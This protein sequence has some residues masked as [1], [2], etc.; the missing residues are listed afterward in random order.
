MML[1]QPLA[2]AAVREKPGTGATGSCQAA[3]G[4]HDRQSRDDEID[5]S[6]IQSRGRVS[7]LGKQG[8]EIMNLR[9]KFVN[10]GFRP[11]HEVSLSAPCVVVLVCPCHLP[12]NVSD[13]LLVTTLG[14]AKM[15]VALPLFSNGSPYR[16]E[17]I[18][19]YHFLTRPKRFVR[20]ALSFN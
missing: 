12:S 4:C 15:F 2:D 5:R 9:R 6:H 17:H 20:N 7:A 8:V 11:I 19:Q 14:M 1:L 10:S 18:N 13:P 3:K 16:I